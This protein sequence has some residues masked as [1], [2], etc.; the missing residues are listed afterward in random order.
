MYFVFKTLFQALYLNRN[1][2]LEIYSGRISKGEILKL[3]SLK[4]L[5]IE[6][7]ETQDLSSSNGKS[8]LLFYDYSW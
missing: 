5:P 7:Y 4:K 8:K 6:F 2:T 1:R 3:Q